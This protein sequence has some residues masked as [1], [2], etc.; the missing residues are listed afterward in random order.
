MKIPFPGFK[1]DLIRFLTQLNKNNHRDW[2]AKNKSRYEAD[3]LGPALEFVEAFAKPLHNIS[4][5]FLSE[6]KKSGGSVMRI[7]RDTR[8][9]K[10]KTPYKTNVGIHFRHQIG[11]DVHSPGFYIHL[12]PDECFLGAG[13]WHPD[14]PT[15]AKI[16]QAILNDPGKWKKCSAGGSFSRNFE[17]AGNSLKRPPRG[18]DPDHPAIHDLKR[19]DFIGVKPVKRAEVENPK[20]LNIVVDSFR[21]STPY[22]KF[23]CE[24]I[25]IPF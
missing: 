8:F 25:G 14:N 11:K 16:R 2:F 13:I 15:L 22:M 20:F 10:D 7:Y 6:P 1:P 17:L 12:A 23:L 21:A 19:K 5:L 4:P 24:A 9:S 3:V 18:I